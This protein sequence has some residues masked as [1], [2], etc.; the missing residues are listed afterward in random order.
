M[1]YP[2]VDTHADGTATAFCYCGWAADYPTAAAAHAAAAAHPAEAQELDDAIIAA[3]R[4]EIFMEA[5]GFATIG[6]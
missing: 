4:A 5:L 2:D 3:E 6:E 1:C